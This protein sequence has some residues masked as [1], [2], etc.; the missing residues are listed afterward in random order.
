MVEQLELSRD[1]SVL[2]FVLHGA[3]YAWPTDAAAPARQPVCDCAIE[4]AAS[5]PDGRLVAGRSRAAWDRQMAL[6]D[7][8][9][10]ACLKRLP[11]HG[12]AAAAFSPDGRWLAVGDHAQ[13][14][15]WSTSDWTPGTKV[16]R[17]QESGVRGCLAF[18]P[19][20]RILA[21]AFSRSTV[22][23]L[24]AP[25][26]R[27]L[28]TLEPPEATNIRSLAFNRDGSQLAVCRLGTGM[29]IWNLSLIRRQLAAMG[30]DW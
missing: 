11:T 28:A 8:P 2:R 27:E 14:Q 7:V 22:R 30:L 13:Y 12:D 16:A 9:A 10:C 17:S 24:E 29:E 1:G 5:S 6:W 3:L 20:G 21:T 15:L 18:S 26:G 4:L 25:S 19:D 23:L